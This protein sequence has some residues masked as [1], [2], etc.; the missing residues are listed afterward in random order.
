M[1]VRTTAL[2]MAVA[3]WTAEVTS[4]WLLQLLVMQLSEFCENVGSLQRHE[5]SVPHPFVGM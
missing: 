1:D 4:A 3:T 5:L 2:Q